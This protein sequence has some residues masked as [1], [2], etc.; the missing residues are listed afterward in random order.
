MKKPLYFW[1]KDKRN[2]P[3]KTYFRVMGQLTKAHARKLEAI[4]FMGDNIM[5]PFKTEA[6]MN[7]FLAAKKAEG[8]SVL[9]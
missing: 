7:K 4:H 9:R 3:L 6:A 1:I 2:P 8:F 5:L